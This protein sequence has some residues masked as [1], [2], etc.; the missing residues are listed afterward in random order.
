M[1]YDEAGTKNIYLYIALAALILVG[2]IG[3]VEREA[4]KVEADIASPELTNSQVGLV[5]IGTIMLGNN[6]DIL[7]IMG[8]VVLLWLVWRKM[9]K[10]VKNTDLLVKISDKRILDHER[11][12]IRTKA[13]SEHVE[14]FLHKRVHRMRRRKAKGK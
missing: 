4:V 12:E 11:I 10:A 7:V 6:I 5:S 9:K 3:C 8:L 14:K 1:E 13:L 2:C